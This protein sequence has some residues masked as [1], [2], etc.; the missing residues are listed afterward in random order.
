M[1]CLFNRKTRE[2]L[3]DFYILLITKYLQPSNA[4]TMETAEGSSSSNDKAVSEN[5]THDS[6]ILN[7]DHLLNEPNQ[8][9]VRPDQSSAKPDQGLIK[10][11]Q[12]VVK[13]DQTTDQASQLTTTTLEASVIRSTRPNVVMATQSHDYNSMMTSLV[14][15]SVVGTVVDQFTPPINGKDQL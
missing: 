7:P 6:A 8:S 3:L 15:T 13:P 4:V 10:P 14:T 1:C 5:K 9:S 12:F 11:S 2:N